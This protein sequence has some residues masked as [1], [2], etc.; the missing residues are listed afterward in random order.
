[1]TEP[2]VVPIS[3]LSASRWSSSPSVTAGTDSVLVSA[4][5]DSSCAELLDLEQPDRLPEAV[6][7]MDGGDELLAEQV[8]G[9][10]HDDGHARLYRRIGGVGHGAVAD[11]HPLD[12]GDR[13]L[14]PGRHDTYPQAEIGG[15]AKAELRHLA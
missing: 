5:G 11:P 8:A 13:I 7:H 15:R 10:R 3:G 6:D 12:V 1:M 14:R 9:L 2:V 4:I